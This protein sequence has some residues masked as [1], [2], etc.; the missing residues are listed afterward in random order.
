MSTTSLIRRDIVSLLVSDCG[1]PSDR[2]EQVGQVHET[3]D[4]RQ[5]DEIDYEET[6]GGGGDVSGVHVLFSHVV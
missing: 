1:V 3:L 6:S 5:D 4:S 2:V